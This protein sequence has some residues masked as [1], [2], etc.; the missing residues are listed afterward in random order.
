M[1]EDYEIKGNILSETLK[2]YGKIIRRSI[3]KMNPLLRLLKI[4]AR[5]KDVQN[6]QAILLAEVNTFKRLT[7]SQ[8]IHIA[9]KILK[10]TNQW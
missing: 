9:I 2:H 6:I 7:K 3:F 8:Q 4:R 1:C 10:V 5:G